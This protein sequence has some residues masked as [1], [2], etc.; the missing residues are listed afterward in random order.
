MDPNPNEQN[1][2]DFFSS[3][4][5]SLQG[6]VGVGITN[7]TVESLI[8]TL[9][10]E[11]AKAAEAAGVALPAYSDANADEDT[12]TDTD[13]DADMNPDMDIDS[14][15]EP[16]TSSDTFYLSNSSAESIA[17]H[18]EVDESSQS[19]SESSDRN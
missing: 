1:N 18:M 11:I 15:D 19:E 14:E 9:R 8:N 16:T 2:D 7:E 10:A 3:L 12:D 17:S 13:T 4:P 6:L 5:Q